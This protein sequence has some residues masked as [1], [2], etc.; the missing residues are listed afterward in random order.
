[1]SE[2]FNIGLGKEEITP[3]VKDAIFLGFARPDQKLSGIKEKLY[4]RTVLFQTKATYFIYVNIEVGFVT[5]SI[6]QT[7][8]SKLLQNPLFKNFSRDQLH[9]T[10][11]HTHSSPGGYDYYP[12]YNMPNNGHVPKILTHITSGIVGSIEKAYKDIS[13]ATLEYQEGNFPQDSEVSFNRSLKA[14]FKNPEVT[15]KN[16]SPKEAA[17]K[18][19]EML[20]IKKNN[21][22]KG[23]INWFP[24]HCTSIGSTNRYVHSDNK[25]I[26]AKVSEEGTDRVCI[27]SQG[28]AGDITPNFIRERQKNRDFRGKFK[29]DFKSAEYNGKLQA[30]QALKILSKG[31]SYKV[32]PLIDS[33]LIYLDFSEMKT[34]DF[35][36]TNNKR[37]AHGAMGV[38]FL[39]GSPVD[40]RAFPDLISNIFSFLA[41]SL[42][43]SHQTKNFV[44]NRKKYKDRKIYEKLHGKKRIILDTGQKKFLASSRS[45]WLHI[46]RHVDPLMNT[47]AIQFFQGALAENSWLPEVLPVQI[48]QLGH[49]ALISIPAETT[50][51]AGKRI[52]LALEPILEKKGISKVIIAPYSNNYCGYITTPEEYEVQFYEGGHTLYG[53][54][55]LPAL[56]YQ[57]EKFATEFLKDKKDRNLDKQS[58]PP[59]FSSQELSKR[60][61]TIL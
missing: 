26:A 21:A 60:T 55:T 59:Q 45:R 12:L 20:V 40:G 13:Q 33:E 54:W 16:L 42:N 53:K 14:Y 5:D 29:D 57:L 44:I 22:I 17:P 27:F 49:V 48:S 6:Y 31:I 61:N 51:M 2:N 3:N 9:I 24:V 8:F 32:E 19:V 37:S 10:A 1:M 43:Y 46:F 41:L 56:T 38:S 52:K 35:T 15:N 36:E 23:F 7:V 4:A 34:K 50:T 25:G 30:D 39:S 18:K 28:N 47:F 11:Q 58:I